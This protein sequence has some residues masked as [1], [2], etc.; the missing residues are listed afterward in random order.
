MNKLATI[1]KWLYALAFIVFGIQHFMYAQFVATLVPGWIPWHLFWAIFAGIAFILAAVSIAVN[2]YA[3]FS[4]I[5]LA[6]MLAVFIVTI[7]IPNLFNNPQNAQ[8]WTRALQDIAIMGTAILLTRDLK[9]QTAGKYLFAVPM[10]VLALQH[11]AHVAFVTARVPAWFPVTEV[12]DYI[13]GIVILLAAVG[14][15]TNRY[16]GVPA[17]MLAGFLLV[18]ALLYHVPLLI[19]DLYNG[20]Q[21]TG[22]MLDIAI[23]GGAFA[24]AALPASYYKSLKMATE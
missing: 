21:W 3:W 12:W 20:Q 18:F 4:G 19:T 10:M 5:M 24:V 17:L 23:A 14:I 11:F 16:M 22:T 8:A 15:I 1:G 6:I 7:H 13:V 9:L 2:K